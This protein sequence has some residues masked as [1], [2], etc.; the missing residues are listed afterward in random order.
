M[1]YGEDC[2][3]KFMNGHDHVHYNHHYQVSVLLLLL[4]RPHSVRFF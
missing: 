2:E 1:N 4:L 3:V